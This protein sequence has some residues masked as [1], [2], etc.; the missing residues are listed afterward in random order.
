QAKDI[1]LVLP[2]ADEPDVWYHG[3]PL[4]VGQVLINLMANAVKFTPE[5]GSIAV[6]VRA[7]RGEGAQQ[8]ACMAVRG[9]GV[10]IEDERVEQRVGAD[11]QGDSGQTRAHGGVGVGLA[12]SRQRARLMGGDIDVSSEPG[13]GSTF[14]LRLPLAAHQD[15]THGMA[16][17]YGHEATG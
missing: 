5:G 8:W 13:A 6:S 16:A 17:G 3:D 7:M 15:A 14:M 1:T 11:V 4:R 12:I 10:G 2:P 9:T